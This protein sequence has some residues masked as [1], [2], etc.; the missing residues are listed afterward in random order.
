M[1]MRQVLFF[2]EA[3]L[4]CL[5]GFQDTGLQ[6]SSSSLIIVFGSPEPLHSR[7]MVVKNPST[8]LYSYLLWGAMTFLC[9]HFPVGNIEVT[10]KL[11][12]A[13][14]VLSQR[15]GDEWCPCLFF[16]SCP[17]FLALSLS[18]SLTHRWTNVH[19]AAIEVPG[20]GGWDSNH[21]TFTLKLTLAAP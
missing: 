20:L 8:L 16:I 3:L 15:R 13:E 11:P 10:P 7:V 19:L 21:P 6:E 1:G 14:T 9:H 5:P 17:L 18:M 4:E 2:T 12:S